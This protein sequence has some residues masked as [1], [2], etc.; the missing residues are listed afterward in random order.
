ME[1]SN[2]LVNLSNKCI[3]SYTEKIKLDKYANNCWKTFIK[4]FVFFVSLTYWDKVFTG[5]R[6]EEYEF[7]ILDPFFRPF[8]LKSPV[9][10]VF[11]NKSLTV[12]Q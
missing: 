2:C 4:Q 11:P 7:R 8:K 12:E 1:L 3:Y 10:G 5:N 9:W 6:K